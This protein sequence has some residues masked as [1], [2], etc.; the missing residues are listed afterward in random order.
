ML[1]VPLPASYGFNVIGPI[2]QVTALVAVARRSAPP[3]KPPERADGEA[4]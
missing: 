3:Y 1:I 4:L 2:V